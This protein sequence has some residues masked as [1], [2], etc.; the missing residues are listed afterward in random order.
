[1][2]L[3][4]QQLVSYAGTLVG[5]LVG[6]AAF[7]WGWFRR[8]A[9]GAADSQALREMHVIEKKNEEAHRQF[10]ERLRA[11]EIETG[12]QKGSLEQIDRRLVEILGILKQRRG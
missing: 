4:A 1:M 12:R 6:G 10:D 7:G 9:A 2:T 3:D 5:G 11:L 8:V